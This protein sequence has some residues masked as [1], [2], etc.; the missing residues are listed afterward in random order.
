V[1]E[2][3]LEIF[4]QPSFWLM[5]FILVSVIYT[6]YRY[7]VYQNEGYSEEEEAISHYLATQQLQYISSEA[8]TSSTNATSRYNYRQVQ[9][10]NTQGE[11]I[12]LLVRIG[13]SKGTLSSVN[14]QA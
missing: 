6:V 9:A 11:T 2:K 4:S 7:F 1:F 5:A 10:Q 14:I 13:Y 12:S 8:Q 3:Y